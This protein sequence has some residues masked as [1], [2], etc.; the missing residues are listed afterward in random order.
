MIDYLD[1]LF[2]MPD[3]AADARNALEQQ[4]RKLYSVYAVR[5]LHCSLLESFIAGHKWASNRDVP[6]PKRD[7]PYIEDGRLFRACGVAIRMIEGGEEAE[8]AIYFAS[9][10]YFAKV[11]DIATTLGNRRGRRDAMGLS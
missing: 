3:P 5:R 7:M 11:H 10:K 1:A 4:E 2:G 8:S 9:Q 6:V